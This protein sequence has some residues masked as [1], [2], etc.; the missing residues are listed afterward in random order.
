MIHHGFLAQVFG[1]DI[2]NNFRE[3]TSK[4]VIGIWQDASVKTRVVRCCWHRVVYVVETSKPDQQ[5]GYGD[6][7]ITHATQERG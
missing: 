6:T 2:D 3:D 1:G 5:K 7:T 4:S